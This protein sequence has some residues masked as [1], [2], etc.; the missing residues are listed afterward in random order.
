MHTQ[1]SC[2]IPSRQNLLSQ[3]CLVSWFVSY[4]F[5]IWLSN[6]ENN[7]CC[8]IWG[9]RVPYSL[10]MDLLFP[11][12]PFQIP[13]YFQYVLLKSVLPYRGTE[14]Q[15]WIFTGLYSP[16]WL[17]PKWAVQPYSVLCPSPPPEALLEEL[18]TVLDVN[19]PDSF[20][21]L[22]SFMEWHAVLML[23][24]LLQVLYF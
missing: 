13:V 23:L 7:M 19:A 11:T 14:W 1:S 20:S 4:L 15:A 3:Y 5:F 9:S 17:A 24:F 8:I 22:F 18:A 2:Y 10:C 16:L 21:L 12:H 6:F